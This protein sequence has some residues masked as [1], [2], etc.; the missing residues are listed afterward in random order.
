MMEYKIDPL[1]QAGRIGCIPRPD[2]DTENRMDYY[3]RLELIKMLLDA[4][5]ALDA[6]E[7]VNEA[8]ILSEY[9]YTSEDSEAD[10]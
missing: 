10:K 6:C 4:R 1:A 2:N 5:P 3:A 9:I 8:R 7:I